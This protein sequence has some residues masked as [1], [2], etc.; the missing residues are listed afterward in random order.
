MSPTSRRQY[1]SAILTTSLIG[2]FNYNLGD[3]TKSLESVGDPSSERLFSRKI[4]DNPKNAF[5][6]IEHKFGVKFGPSP[7]PTIWPEGDLE[8]LKAEILKFDADVVHPTGI[9][10]GQVTE[11]NAHDSVRSH[12]HTKYDIAHLFQMHTDIP[13]GQIFDLWY[14]S[15]SKS[16]KWKRPDGTIVTHPKEIAGRHFDGTPWAR[17]DDAD[18]PEDHPSHG[19]GPT[20]ITPTPHAEGAKKLYIKYAAK[21]F[22]LGSTKFWFDS[23]PI[24]GS[25]IDFSDWAE[26]TFTEHLNDLPR[27]RLD[28]LGIGDPDEFNFKSYLLDKGIEPTS[29]RHP[30]E[31]AIFREY[32]RHHH[33]SFKQFYKDVFSE[34]RANLPADVNDAGT[35]VEGNQMGLQG[36]RT[37]AFYLSDTVDEISIEFAPTV[38]PERPAAMAVKT[39]RAAGKF[40]KSVRLYGRIDG[41]EDA[42]ELGLD[43]SEYYTTLMRFQAAQIYAHGGRFEIR[44]NPRGSFESTAD[45][46]SRPDGSV[47]DELHRFVDFIQAHKRFLKNIMEANDA[48]IVRSLPTM[49]WHH[50]PPW[51]NSDASPEG[52]L[53]TGAAL[54]LEH[55]P[56]DV[57]VLDY[58]PLWEAP[59]QYA[60]LADYDLIVLANVDCM[61]DAHVQSIE[62][63]IESDTRV[64]SIGGA[65][66]R[67]EEFAER[68]DVERLLSQSELGTIIDGFP[69]EA[70]QNAAAMELRD[71][72]SSVESQIEVNVDADVSI[73]IVEQSDPDRIIVHLLNYE[74]DP[75][76]DSMPTQRGIEVT[77]R[78]L[79]FEPAAATWHTQT[80]NI[81]V[82]PSGEANQ[83]S[84]TVPHLDVWGFIVFGETRSVIESEVNEESAI[85]A[86]NDAREAV[87]TARDGNR[88]E[89]LDKASAKLYKAEAAL[90]HSGYSV[91][92]EKAEDAVEWAQKAY[93]TPTIGIDQAHDQ[94]KHHLTSWEEL[95]EFREA[96]SN[97]ELLKIQNW[98]AE[99]FEEID[100][101]FVPPSL[102][103]DGYGFTD[104]DLE[105][106][107]EFVENG[108]G[109]V[110]TATASGGLANDLD[111]LTSTF[112]F[113][114]AGA[115]IGTPEDGRIEV[116]TEYSSLTR[117]YLG[118]QEPHTVMDDVEDCF[119]WARIAEDSDAWINRSGGPIS[120]KDPQDEA[121]AGAP[122]GIATTHGDGAV[123]GSCYLQLW[124]VEFGNSWW[125]ITRNQV[126]VLG[127]NARYAQQKGR[128]NEEKDDGKEDDGSRR[129]DDGSGSEDGDGRGTA[130]DG[131]DMPGFGIGGAI[132]GLVGLLYIFKRRLSDIPE[133]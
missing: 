132:A 119:V 17:Q 121:A 88:D 6:G 125:N 97:H 67:D 2:G 20:V 120:E 57:R 51:R 18:V 82:E 107:E 86:V 105:L 118:E 28:E 50:A 60:D 22:D 41:W 124:N 59:Q 95:D 108:G 49:V 78:D 71:A 63:A 75:E 38:P 68:E 46:W 5:L 80:G 111:D 112:G 79:P 128:S 55:V 99:V 77:V 1:L 117:M 35:S 26:A 65:P 9:G 103:T 90:D 116:A 123:V 130:S 133:Q 40:Q 74:Y 12:F 31:D 24:P 15:L 47:G 100:I 21:A 76:T 56:Y 29:T 113:T 16:A 126:S 36:Q 10:I 53:G 64:V 19:E 61:S 104:R 27:R 109:L 45:S 66:T 93:R 110:V 106:V 37:P 102:D 92:M 91:A 81:S 62:K 52:V 94:S 131:M 69:D 129:E 87:E 7:E 44:L 13:S 58:P 39:G 32:V 127:R 11:R 72:A 83:V 14:K 70:A 8:T 115:E 98:S 43:P 3:R 122:V 23:F 84:V 42:K 30:A 54:R 85:Q 34:G 48:V 4:P 96:F 25:R 33:T 101:L 89:L 73:N 114:I